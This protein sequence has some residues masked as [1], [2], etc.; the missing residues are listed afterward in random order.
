MTGRTLLKA[1]VE[2]ARADERRKIQREIV[3]PLLEMITV[4]SPDSTA[5]NV[6]ARWSRENSAEVK[7]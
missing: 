7:R 4:Y 3:A 1:E 6:A 2:Q 5:L